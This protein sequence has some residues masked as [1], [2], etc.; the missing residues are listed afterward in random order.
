MHCA[1][2][3]LRVS[4]G[5]EELLSERDWE[6][7]LK[8]KTF[9][10][11]MAILIVVVGGQLDSV[12]VEVDAISK[13]GAL[14]TQCFSESQLSACQRALT[15]AEVLQRKA[16]FKGSYACQSRLLGLGADLL[17]ISFDE[18]RGGSSFEMLEKV[19]MLCS[20]L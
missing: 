1:G 16:A 20:D 5:G 11:S 12:A 18:G 19:Q 17:M 3:H 2:L 9:L 6:V 13:L 10:V 15:L 8:T 14:S 7:S 4:S